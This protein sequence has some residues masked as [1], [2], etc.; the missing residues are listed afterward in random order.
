MFAVLSDSAQSTFTRCAPTLQLNACSCEV[1]I[2][3]IGGSL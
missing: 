2:S 1:P 3:L